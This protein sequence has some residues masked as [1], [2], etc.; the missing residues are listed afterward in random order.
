[1]CGRYDLNI[2]AMAMA[3]RFAL[4]TR[5]ESAES[6]ESGVNERAAEAILNLEAGW[7]PRYNIAPGLRNP[8][9]VRDTGGRN[10][11]ALMQ[12]GLVPAWS[13]E[14]KV[15][16]STIN[17]RAE[18]VAS[19]P[20]FRKAL[21]NRRCLVPATGYFEWAK[22]D[23]G[24]Q[25]YRIQVRDDSHGS[26]DGVFAF[27]GLFDIWRGPGGQELQTYAIVTTGANDALSA[28]HSR[29][30]VILPA[31]AEGAWLD[32]DNDMR[33]ETLLSLLQPYP[34]ERMTA[35]PVSSLVNSPANDRREIL[36]PVRLPAA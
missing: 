2:T 19:K 10:E 7:K 34:G 32:A 23:N 4:S 28:I 13:R 6:G 12:W 14:P 11:L 30:P 26:G 3:A 16:Y 24:K 15:S 29:M 35:Y 20:T 36:E 25:P 9:I 22:V 33:I 8:V 21:A 31:E 18:T 5:G 17:A 1:M 27:A